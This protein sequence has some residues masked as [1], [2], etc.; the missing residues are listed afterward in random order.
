MVD[1][2]LL[3]PNFG[4]GESAT[5]GPPRP[6]RGAST[7]SG[8]HLQHLKARLGIPLVASLNGVTPS[9][10]VELGREL[11]AGRRRRAGTQRLAP[12]GP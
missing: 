11:E 3:H 9:G 4:D 1:R 8:E 5:S 7:L 12:A 10:W 2:F 6:L